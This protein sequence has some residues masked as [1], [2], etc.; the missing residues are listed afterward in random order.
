MAAGAIGWT[1]RLDDVVAVTPQHELEGV[2]YKR[3]D[4]RYRPGRRTSAWRKHKHRRTETLAVTAWRPGDR[5][6]D[7]FYLARRRPDGA[8]ASA[9]A[10]QLGLTPDRREELRAALR[11]L[12]TTRERRRRPR[13]V[14]PGV[15]L[16]VSAHGCADAPLRDAIIRDIV[17]FPDVAQPPAG[18]RGG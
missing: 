2:V 4:S 5:E 17:S 12:E 14:A 10:A 15:A 7:T 1:G 9:G 16:V 6:P 8:L 3:L 18:Q 13:P 11:G